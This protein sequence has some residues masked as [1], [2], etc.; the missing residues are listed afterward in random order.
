MTGRFTQCSRNLLNRPTQSRLLFN[1]NNKT[2]FHP[3]CKHGD[4][5]M[6]F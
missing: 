6:I 3:V 1:D 5:C 4:K 2:P